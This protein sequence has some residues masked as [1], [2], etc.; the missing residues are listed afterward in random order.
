MSSLGLGCDT[1]KGWG[2]C[3]NEGVSLG[4]AQEEEE[5]D[6]ERKLSADQLIRSVWSVR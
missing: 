2:E 6:D 5:D 4:V 1:Y 3:T